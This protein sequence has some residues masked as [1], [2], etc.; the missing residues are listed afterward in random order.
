MNDG[1]F[2]KAFNDVIRG[3]DVLTK[4]KR[5]V[6]DELLRL[7]DVEDE[8][9]ADAPYAYHTDRD[10]FLAKM[11]FVREHA[12]FVAKLGVLLNLNK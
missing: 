11:G 9:W 4:L 10:E 5:L 2:Q 8:I 12:S 7:I 1:D 3:D 6:S